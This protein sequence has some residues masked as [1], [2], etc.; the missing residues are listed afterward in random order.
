MSFHSI[1]VSSPVRLYTIYAGKMCNLL[2]ATL[3]FPRVTSFAL[4]NDYAANG[5]GTPGRKAQMVSIAK[6]SVEMFDCLIMGS[7]KRINA[8]E[9]KC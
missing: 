8:F 2:L 1:S 4:S 5:F 7:L 3:C 6:S 9:I